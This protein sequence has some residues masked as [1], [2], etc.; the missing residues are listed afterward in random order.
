[1][2]YAQVRNSIVTLL[3]LLWLAGCGQTPGLKRTPPL[4]SDPDIA[5]AAQLAA[6]GD[7]LG[8]AALYS[9]VAQRVPANSQG[10]LWVRAAE[11]FRA[12]RDLDSARTAL[13]AAASAPMEPLT[14]LRK[15]LLEAELLMDDT[16]ASDA[17]ALLL[18]PLPPGIPV[19]LAIRYRLDTARAFRLMGNLLE[20]AREL[21]VL[22]GLLAD[23]RKR[24]DNQL[25]IV[26]SLAVLSDPALRSLQP[27][28]PGIEGGWMELARVL[29]QASANPSLLPNLL[30]AW[31]QQ[32]PTHP[33][34]P[35]LLEGYFEQQQSL[36]THAA[37]VAVLLPERGPYAKVAAA[38]RDG[39]MASWYQDAEA[40]RP[41]LR[42][43][44]SSN[45]SALW[46]TYS[47]AVA[48]G[49]DMVI[50]PLEKEAVE[51]LMRAGDLPVPVL[52]LNQV[53]IEV[54]PPANLFQFSLSPEGEA[55][56]VAEHA[57]LKGRR[58]PAVLTPA[59]EWG[60]RIA[61]AFTERWLS[62]GGEVA[63]HQNYDATSTDHSASIQ[64]L[65]L[66]D[67]S[68]QRHN[69]LQ[70]LLG[71]RIEFEPRRRQDIDMIFIA[72]RP[73]QTRMLR[74]QLQF[75]HADDIP[76]YATSHAWTGSI[77]RREAE[78]VSGIFLLDMP[79]YLTEDDTSPVSR[80]QLR[81]ALP[82]AGGAYG[83]LYAM[84]LDAYILLPHLARLKSSRLESLEGHTGNLSNDGSNQIQRQLVWVKLGLTPE[85]LGY[86]PRLDLERNAPLAPGNAATQPNS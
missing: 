49:A 38:I 50:G 81:Q 74:P 39:L 34:M 46:P 45:T 35:G 42:F 77:K 59:G 71:M 31:R 85:I 65:M 60:D 69:A 13:N 80:A 29:K 55:R 73:K 70:R 17:L 62:L 61:T 2:K 64:Q 66:L 37:H 4:E 48:E 18:D 33:A 43:Y 27:S 78:D 40:S 3:L 54:P 44:D 11:N 63:G 58:R 82:A 6:Q 15:R 41:E 7:F 22:D 16:R 12:G 1:M 26:R 30:A 14:Q 28:P 56:Q 52:A 67:A 57:W 36:I 5:R 24:F 53:Q 25:E 32:F 8:A 75:H 19:D 86:S 79:W 20:S 9:A 72:A 47:Q 68:R 51:L 76:V 84:G 83:R 23:P 21:Q 10:E